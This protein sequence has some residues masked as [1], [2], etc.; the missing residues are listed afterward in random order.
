MSENPVL[1]AVRTAIITELRGYEIYKAA[2]ERAADP[3][4]RQMF[5][6]LADDE[7]AHKEF[8][9]LN[10]RSLLAGGGWAVPAT[11]ENLSPLDHTDI[12]NAD[13]LR[14]VRGGSFEMAVIAAGVEL[15]RS[16]I[17]YYNEQAMACPDETGRHNFRFLAD[18]EKG[19]LEAL[20][21]LE[22]Q[23]RD[24]Y[25]AEQGFSRM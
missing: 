13:F 12:I 15:E 18:W 6:C 1:E 14:R 22:R 20:V 23:M 4:A 19:H 11:P 21:D 24:Q 5:Q 9:E 2:A 16:A 8:L 17:A 7:K 10:Y 3:S 25:F